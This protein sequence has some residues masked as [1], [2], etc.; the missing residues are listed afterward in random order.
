MTILPEY[1]LAFYAL[2]VPVFPFMGF[3]LTILLTNRDRA[4]TIT[5]TTMA[6]L[7]ATFFAMVSSYFLFV[8]PENAFQ[9]ELPW[10]QA[11]YMDMSLTFSINRFSTVCA[12]V[13]CILSTLINFFSINITK[14]DESSV[15]SLYFSL[16]SLN[17]ACLTA[18]CFSGSLN[19]ICGFLILSS[20]TGFFLH[21]VVYMDSS[22]KM[23]IKRMFIVHFLADLLTY[24]GAVMM[25]KLA[26]TGMNLEALYSAA[27]N[28][29]TLYN[30]FEGFAA[31]ILLVSSFVVRAGIF[32]F[33][34]LLTNFQEKASALS[35]ITINLNHSTAAMIVLVLLKPVLQPAPP[36]LFEIL[37][38]LAL[39][40]AVTSSLKASLGN[41]I[42]SVV[43]HLIY[44]QNSF[45]TIIFLHSEGAGGMFLLFETVSLMTLVTL[46]TEYIKSVMHS[47]SVWEIGNIRKSMK[48]TFFVFTISAILISGIPIFSGFWKNATTI[49]IVSESLAHL[50]FITLATMLQ[51]YAV[52]RLYCILFVNGEEPGE[53]ELLDNRERS[54]S[55]SMTL[56]MFTFLI[57][58]T[59]IV[60]VP[61]VKNIINDLLEQNV[62]V[63]ASSPYMI[64]SSLSSL[65]GIVAAFLL[66]SRQA[67]EKN[68]MLLKRT[69]P[70]VYIVEHSFGLTY[71][72][73]KTV[74][75][76]N[77][78]LARF[79]TESPGCE[80]T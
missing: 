61:F 26:G 67:R 21:T 80:T 51:A 24:S 70:L 35:V 62:S 42:S 10:L 58:L 48:V 25:A 4:S 13:I 23:G 31:A 34:L 52:T 57:L 18:M 54:V 41:D 45:L 72:F 14:N 47:N 77:K 20:V 69:G 50:I 60:D 79:Y 33:N 71:L 36:G 17:L 78:W 30:G 3:I 49:S 68:E 44:V 27:R 12:M 22:M 65:A 56:G 38:V 15:S 9:M 40:T 53:Q 19:Q 76:I 43:K 5:I 37:T 55:I 74:S 46:L 63:G 7:F 66:F 32:P 29:F 73:R 6:S 2:S 8:M 1:I 16:C 64:L 28:G 75:V 11:E 39:A 59:G